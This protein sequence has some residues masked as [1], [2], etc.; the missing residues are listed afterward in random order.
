MVDSDQLHKVMVDTMPEKLKD[1]S[2][3]TMQACSQ[4]LSEAL[5]YSGDRIA[6]MQYR[7]RIEVL[8]REI[9]L[10]RIE[11]RS[12]RQHRELY[13]VARTTLIWVIVTGIAALVA[14]YGSLIRDTFFSKAQPAN[15]PQ[16]TPG[17]S[18]QT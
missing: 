8:R 2:T 5:N 10:R 4:Y 3:E 13:G 18:L 7:D 12:E 6:L 1:L 11:E 17:S 16:S 14:E 9:E 15:A